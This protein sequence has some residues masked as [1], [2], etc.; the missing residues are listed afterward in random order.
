[1]E[2]I[3]SEQDNQYEIYIIKNILDGKAYIGV[4]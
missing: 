4:A 3:T 1:M 2:T